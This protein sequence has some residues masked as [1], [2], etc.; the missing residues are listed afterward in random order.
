MADPVDPVVPLRLSET[1]LRKVDDWRR[2]QAGLPS[3]EEAVLRL[4]AIGLETVSTPGRRFWDR[5]PSAPQPD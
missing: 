1:F 4:I 2:E 5:K 3:R